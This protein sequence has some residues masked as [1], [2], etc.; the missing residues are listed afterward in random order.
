MNLIFTLLQ[1]FVAVETSTISLAGW[2]GRGA[3]IARGGSF[4]RESKRCQDA[5]KAYGAAGP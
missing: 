3:E 2:Q 1:R 5:P 4:T